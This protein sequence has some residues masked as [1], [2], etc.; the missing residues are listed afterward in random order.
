MDASIRTDL[1]I[2]L[3]WVNMKLNCSILL[4]LCNNTNN[5]ICNVFIN[6]YTSVDNLQNYLKN[7]Q[8]PTEN[9]WVK[10]SLIWELISQITSLFLPL[11]YF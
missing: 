11:H 7:K 8:K 4:W 10:P 9:H 6:S 5:K 2:V 3:I 1:K